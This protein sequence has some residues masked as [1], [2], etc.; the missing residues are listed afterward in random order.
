[1]TAVRAGKATFDI[2]VIAFDKDGTLV[3][4]NAYWLDPSRRWVE[5]AAGGVPELREELALSL[6]LESDRLRPDSPLAAGTVEQARRLTREVLE[7]RGMDPDRAHERSQLALEAAAAE[8]ATFALRP[9][10]DVPRALHRL[11]GA[12][13]HLAVITS[14]D[15]EPAATALNQLGVSELVSLVLS[16]DGSL[17]P[18]PYGGLIEAVAAHFGTTASRVLMVGDSAVDAQTA[19]SGGAAGFVLVAAD[20]D[21][22]RTAD[23]VVG[24]V[25]EIEPI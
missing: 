3:D 12:G 8:S 25:D 4:L 24:S 11:S 20:A 16:G 2:D 6:G 1:M 18:K 19:R 17:P 23:A 9:L 22:S 10:G 13:L 5:V 7:R 14:D 21:P 15:C